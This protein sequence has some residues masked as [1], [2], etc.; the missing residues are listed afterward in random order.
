MLL[1]QCVRRALSRAACT[2]GKSNATNMP[3]IAITTRSSINVKASDGR[4]TLRL[5]RHRTG[6]RHGE[7]VDLGR[8]SSMKL[9]FRIDE[10]RGELRAAGM[11]ILRQFDAVR[12]TPPSDRRPTRRIPLAHKLV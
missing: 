2:A 6:V 11:R 1:T 5:V 12:N 3:I 9:P 8:N 4:R 7:F 10:N